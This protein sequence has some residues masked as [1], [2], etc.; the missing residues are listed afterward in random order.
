MHQYAHNELAIIA[1]RA[2][3]ARI[4]RELATET[5]VFDFE[6]VLPT[7]EALGPRARQEWRRKHWGTTGQPGRG[8]RLLRAAGD[9]EVVFYVF[10]TPQRA[11][12]AL[13]AHVAACYPL[14]EILLTCARGG[15]PGTRTL[16]WATGRLV[17]RTAL[18]PASAVSERR[19]GHLSPQPSAAEFR[20]RPA[21]RLCR[22]EQRACR[23]CAPPRP[24]RREVRQ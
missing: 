20:R 16:A 10:A 23:R 19:P 6:R 14:A 24:P 4:E 2:E 13:V 11:P 12:V 5:S 22:R 9:E 15:L 8:A 7:P 21:T 3:L 18:E 1:P 17:A